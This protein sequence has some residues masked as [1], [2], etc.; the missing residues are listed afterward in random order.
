MDTK[1]L[2]FMMNSNIV[3]NKNDTDV[4]DQVLFGLVLGKISGP[5]KVLPEIYAT[6]SLKKEIKN[7][8]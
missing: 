2:K 7:N 5:R 4:P 8:K 6:E 3:V 1:I